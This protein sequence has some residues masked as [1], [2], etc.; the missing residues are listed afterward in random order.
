MPSCLALF[1]E[2]VPGRQAAAYFGHVGFTQVRVVTDRFA[3]DLDVV[4]LMRST[5][6]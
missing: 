5:L 2:M 6:P 3:S 1:A 4:E